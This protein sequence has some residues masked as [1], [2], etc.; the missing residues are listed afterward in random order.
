VYSAC[1]ADGSVLKAL[2][3]GDVCVGAYST[4]AAGGVWSG[5]AV[6]VVWRL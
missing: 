4:C 6:P 1:A 2:V 5:G 3:A